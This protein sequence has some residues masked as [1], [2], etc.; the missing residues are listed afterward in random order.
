M[1][2]TRK[3]YMT[4]AVKGG[5]IEFGTVTHDAASLGAG[6]S[7]EDTIT[8]TGGDTLELG[9]SDMVFVNGRNVDTGIVVTG[10]RVTAADTLKVKLFNPTGSGVD[11]GALTFDVL[12]IHPV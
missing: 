6:V 10:A 8:L 1:A 3:G 12:V 9:T 4:D 5:H 11:A 2:Y 7:R